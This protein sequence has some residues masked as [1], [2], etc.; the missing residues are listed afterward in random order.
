MSPNAD[1]VRRLRDAARRL[2]GL[3]LADTREDALCATL[4]RRA[5]ACRASVDEY[6]ARL[7][8]LDPT[9]PESAPLAAELTVGE[10]YFFRHA[11]QLRAFAEVVVPERA[12]AR[13]DGRQLRVLS[14]G[15]A[16]GEEA[17]SLAILLREA[18]HDT[19]PASVRG[20]DL[21]ADA[22]RRAERGIYS[23]WA[24]RETPEPIRAR[25]L[26]ARGKE[27]VVD[28]AI[29]RMVRFDV[30]N[31]LDPAADLGPEAAYDVIFCRN[32]LMYLTHD[33]MRAV[34][35]RLGRLLVPGGYLFLGHAETLRGLSSEYQLQQAHGAFFYRRQDGAT[36]SMADALAVPPSTTPPSTQRWHDTIRE[37]TERVRLLADRS[38]DASR[39]RPV[40]P[41]LARVLD[42]AHAERFAD[43]LELLG[44]DDDGSADGLLVRAALLTQ[45][46]ALAEAEAACRSLLA[47]DTLHAGA[48]Y[49]LALCREA[50]GDL[51]EAQR[52]DEMAAHLDPGFAMPRLH[53]GLGA[54]RRGA[55]EMARSELARA[56]E[57]LQREEP[58]RILLFGG[59]FAREALLSLCRSELRA[60]GAEP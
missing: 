59:G 22:V 23:S 9:S 25:W 30:C 14:A 57:L 43:A 2:F 52:H 35:A 33:A 8:A 45:R 55:L 49:L 29:R 42:L 31:L 21:R 50:S 48:H 5:A 26:R 27:H 44:P 6:V 28:D 54:R 32:V 17:Y 56:L 58:A 20:V 7:D 36:S 39:P 53:L 46:G 1:A 47:I 40:R 19:G 24:L 18:G 12:R 41:S 15:C 37:A 10:T 11:E 38:D 13:G 3:H 60:C 16:S 4:E 51:E 34:V